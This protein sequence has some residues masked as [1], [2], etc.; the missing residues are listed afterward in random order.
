MKQNALVLGF[1]NILLQ[2]EGLGVRVVEHLQAN[3]DLTAEIVVFNGSAMPLDLSF[4]AD[5]SWLH[6]HTPIHSPACHSVG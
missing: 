4:F 1:G 5:G 2:D 3:Y 6:R